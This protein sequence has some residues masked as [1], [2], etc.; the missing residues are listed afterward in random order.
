MSDNIKIFQL[1]SYVKPLPVEN[2]QRNWVLNGTKNSFYQYLIDMNDDSSTLSSVH[3]SYAD[4][5]Y[6]G[7]LTYTNGQSGLNDWVKL[8]KY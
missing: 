7:G 4:Y 8:K 1:A 6:G 3:K 5:I 2:R